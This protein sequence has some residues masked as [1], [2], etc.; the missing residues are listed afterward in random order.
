VSISGALNTVS[1]DFTPLSGE[2]TSFMSFTSFMLETRII[3]FPYRVIYR[4]IFRIICRMYRRQHQPKSVCNASSSL[5]IALFDLI[6]ACR[7]LHNGIYTLKA[8]TLN[9]SAEPAVA[10]G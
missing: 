5:H 7:S 10:C 6:F 9:T 2:F 1:G 8:F 3:L 4:I